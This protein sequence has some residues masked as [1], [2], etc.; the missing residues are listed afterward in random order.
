MKCGSAGCSNNNG[1]LMTW[2]TSTGKTSAF[3][4]FYPFPT[5]RQ[6]VLPNTEN[7]YTTTRAC[8]YIMC[9]RR[10]CLLAWP[11]VAGANLHMITHNIF[12][13]KFFF[14]HLTLIFIVK[15]KLPDR[16]SAVVWMDL[17]D[18]SICKLYLGN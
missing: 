7:I 10:D 4:P 9:S 5:F 15:A 12:Y 16:Y 1:G 18:H 2:E 14:F 11:S 17:V 3:W 8:M 6:S 13:N